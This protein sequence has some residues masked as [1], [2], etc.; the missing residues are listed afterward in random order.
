MDRFT[1][2]LATLTPE[3][4]LLLELLKKQKNSRPASEQ[5]KTAPPRAAQSVHESRESCAPFSLISEDDRRRLPRGIEDAYPLTMIQLGMLSHMDLRPDAP[6]PP[7]YH[8]VNSFHLRSPFDFAA[9]DEAV[10][11]VIERHAI[12]R[13]SFD[14]VTYSRPVQLVHRTARMSVG[15]ADLRELSPAEQAPVL[16]DFIERENYNLFDLS[17]PPLLRFFV[18]RL[19]DE[20]FQLTLTEPHAVSDGWS[21]NLTLAEMCEHYYALL[22]HQTPPNA[23]P[24]PVAFRDFVRMEQE[25]LE[26][27]AC[28]RFWDA[29]LD[30]AELTRLPR[31]P[32]PPAA[33]Q[34]IEDHKLDFSLNI[35]LTEALHRVARQAGVPL[36]SV[37][38]AAHLKA[39]CVLSGCNDVLTGM[40][41]N[42]RP[43]VPGGD[44]VRGLFLNTLPVRCRVRPGT[45]LDL[46]RQA[47][48]AELEVLP[49]RRYP[50]PALQM[51]HGNRPL[52]ETA[53]SYL[54]FHSLEKTLGKVED[55]G[56]GGSDLSVTNFPFKA[57]FHRSVIASSRLE[58]SFEFDLEDFDREHVRS[59]YG[60]YERA[61]AALTADPRARHD[62]ASLLAPRERQLLSESNETV[63]EFPPRE[64]VQQ[65]FEEWAA[66][67]PDAPALVFE[68]EQLSFCELNRRANQLARA[69]RK[70]GV[71]PEVCVGLHMERT[72][73]LIVGLLG[74]LKSGG[75]YVPLDPALPRERLAF[76]CE[77]ARVALV[78][79]H[80]RHRDSVPRGSWRVLDLDA[81]W[82]EI[83]REDGENLVGGAS[84]ANL[85]YVIFTSGST[86]RPKG[87]GVEHRQL[88]N[89]VRAV[90]RVLELPPGASYAM[91]STFAA[92]LGNTTLFPSLCGGGCLHIVGQERASDPQAVAEYFEQHEI[93]CLKIVPSHLAG[94]LSVERPRRVL[95]R[96]RLVLG[97]EACQ[98][99]LLE[100][101]GALAPECRVVNHYGP[102]ETTVGALTFDAR[103]AG[104]SHGA[105]TVPIGLPLANAQAYL[106]DED[107]QP[108]PVSTPGELYVGGAGVARGYLGRPELTA[109]RFIPDPFS[110]EPGARL[111]R[112]G[113]VARRLPSGHVEFLGRRDEQIKIR[114][115][116]V[117]PGEVD[118]ALSQHPRVR[119]SVTVVRTD[120]QGE[121]RLVAYVV[122]DAGEAAPDAAAL[123]DFLKA[124]LPDYM[125]PASFVELQRLPLTP[126]G[127]VDR[128]ALPPPKEEAQARAQAF[129][130]PRT[131]IEEM[132]AGICARVLGRESVGAFDD[133]F[134]LG[135]HSLL[136][137]QLIA[138]LREAFRADLHVRTIF[139]TPTVAEMARHIESRLKAG[140][141]TTAPP[142][143][144]VERDTCGLPLSFA[145]QRL[146]F[147]DQL[148]PGTATY[149]IPSALRVEGRLDAHALRR[150]LD[151][152]V[153][154]HEA[155]R[156]TFEVAD[157]EPRQFVSGE[158]TLSL[159][160]VDLRGLPAAEREQEARRLAD[161]EARRPF[162]L[163]RGPLLR[164]ALVQLADEEHVLLFTMHHIISDAWSSG[165]LVGELAELYESFVAGREPSLPELPVQY[166][167]FAAWQRAWLGGEVL[168][169]QL[170]YWVKQLAGAP[171][172]IELPTDYPRPPLQTYRG[173]VRYLTLPRALT[174]KLN[175]L[176]RREGVTLFMTLLAAFQTLLQRYTGQTD[177]VVGTPVA[178][179]SRT[180]VERLIGVFINTL[181][182]RADF[183][184]DP[185]FREL[186]KRV[187]EAA[188]GAYAHQEL[189]FEKLVEELQPVRDLSRSP[190]FQVMFVLQ[191]A[192]NEVLGAGGLRLSAV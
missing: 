18:H 138:R 173:A 4:R 23:P 32:R 40:V 112:T 158:S 54:H 64:G 70:R 191:P 139:E 11:R 167:D 176:S 69:L 79:T 172:P 152:V 171:A 135:G 116:R 46:A 187:R 37:L 3:K 183:S 147:L 33:A 177:I 49:H 106:L 43:E 44:E 27:E 45:W 24:P 68:G 190:L 86:G 53:F 78:L 36:K 149:N 26:S 17:R 129:I 165:V 99:W 127:K 140:G 125:L 74:V 169:E 184:G 59:F 124:T 96:A 28:Q 128:R 111:Y 114:G 192:A 35:Q 102:T 131:P 118:A 113:D 162:D 95:P 13:T 31:R 29:K 72:P 181:V 61:L 63:A 104:D 142:L 137:F 25:A 119:A 8:N 185:T 92:D 12:L 89:Y 151:E 21:T 16:R 134:D 58:L 136:A 121:H 166:G 160:F 157:G 164:A 161:E 62:A 156:T 108:A 22:N 84:P 65:L 88:L 91:L 182:M 90:A 85:V 6:T 15:L 94:L 133:F 80:E 130:A 97:G 48:E 107:A 143:V 30:G 178:G 180:E 109:E 5:E 71:G 159:P 123:R 51:R 82:T 148:Q 100:R 76:M 2:R 81:D 9:F 1:E 41:F 145:Q 50:L 83:A 10:N 93:D 42:G 75:A 87:V 126:N 117:E 189:P 66:A 47:Y 73:E 110:R 34:T 14:L 163:T 132:V 122:C 146:W 77:E 186:L 55:V 19:T 39:M 188:L 101:V 174:E 7:A 20:T 115:Y 67:T 57:T 98:R 60:Y 56:A 168:R 175:E 38:F 141:G 105:A 155:L 170:D 120:V 179:R 150:S 144:R 52:F 103:R 153:R 154:R